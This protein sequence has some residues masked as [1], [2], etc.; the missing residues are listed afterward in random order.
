MKMIVLCIIVCM[1][2]VGL[3][4]IALSDSGA[5]VD[6]EFIE[7]IPSRLSAG[8]PFEFI[9]RCRNTGNEPINPFAEVTLSGGVY[10]SDDKQILNAQD[11]KYRLY[12]F[13]PGDKSG[14]L[15]FYIGSLQKGSYML[16][17]N[18]NAYSRTKQVNIS[19]S[20]YSMPITVD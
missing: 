7:F 6:V 9:F 18:I 10:D 14:R 12:N 17:L 13:F 8:V 2:S 16:K 4:D 19:N 15:R 3:G 5:N 20:T 1:L 11:K